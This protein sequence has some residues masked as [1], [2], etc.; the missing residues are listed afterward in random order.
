MEFLKNAKRL[1]KQSLKK[2]IGGGGLAVF[3]AVKCNSFCSISIPCNAGCSC[4]GNRCAEDSLFGG[5]LFFIGTEIA[6]ATLYHFI[7]IGSADATLYAR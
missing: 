7:G 1:D 4:A 3:A 2:V 6:D 5:S